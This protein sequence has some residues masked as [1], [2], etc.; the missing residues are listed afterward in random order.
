MKNKL[1]MSLMNGINQLMLNGELRKFMDAKIFLD[2]IVEAVADKSQE[3]ADVKANTKQYRKMFKSITVDEIVKKSGK[4]LWVTNFSFRTDA[5]QM[6]Y[7]YNNLCWKRIDDNQKILDFVRACCEKMGL[8]EIEYSDVAFMKQILNDLAMKVSH[9]KTA[10]VPR[11][12]T[13]INFQNGVLELKADGTKGFREHRMED[14]LFYVLPYC[15]DPAALWEQ[16]QEFLDVSVPDRDT[17]R[18]LAEYLAYCLDDNLRCEKMLALFGLGSN[19]KSVILEV[20]ENIIGKDNVSYASLSD[21]SNDAEKR[22]Q[23][24]GKKVNISHESD[25]KL[26]FANTKQLISGDPIDVR[27]LYFGTYTITQYAKFI[28]SFNTLPRAENTHGWYRRWIIIPMNTIIPDEKQDLELTDKLVANELPGI[29]NWILQSLEQLKANN[30]KIFISEECRTSLQN[31]IGTSDSVRCF[32]NEWCEQDSE[33]QFTLGKDL[34]NAYKRF[35]YD[36]LRKPKGKQSFFEGLKAIGIERSKYQNR[37]IFYLKLK[38][39]YAMSV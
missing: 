6:F 26:D 31:Y 21:L 30:G 38:Q 9:Q 37:D 33:G 13:L 28:T 4:R 20:L 10:F 19:G 5:V 17:Q 36:D 15:Y 16:W 27:K 14:E 2:Q 34:F 24:E 3:F 1:T 22:T 12:M 35:C 25:Q 29:F 18:T 8:P 39:E 32:V 11:G 23:I 7:V